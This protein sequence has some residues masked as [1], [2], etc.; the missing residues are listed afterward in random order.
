MCHLIAPS[1][2]AWVAFAKRPSAQRHREAG[3]GSRCPFAMTRLRAS[4]L[5]YR[6]VT[7]APTRS[8]GLPEVLGVRP[9]KIVFP[10][11]NRWRAAQAAGSA[12]SEAVAVPRV[13]QPAR[14]ASDS[15]HGPPPTCRLWGPH[16]TCRWRSASPGKDHCSRS[17]ETP[18]LTAV[19]AGRR[20]EPRGLHLLVSRPKP[21]F[22][23][24]G[25]PPSTGTRSVCC[26]GGGQSVRGASRPGGCPLRRALGAA[27]RSGCKR[28]RPPARARPS[29]G[30]GRSARARADVCEKF[31]F[32]S[33]CQGG[34]AT[35][36][37]QDGRRGLPAEDSCR[38]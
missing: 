2:G 30:P 20:C 24:A 38:F 34:D 4:A 8:P 37:S 29:E 9:V 36:Q 7:S 13:M 6:A 26:P 35:R 5:R 3:E 23:E 28:G 15:L 18:E 14:V 10:K 21:R 31:P 12:L 11:C 16:P 19:G 25:W 27:A 33:H 1:P 22:Q 17:T 32:D